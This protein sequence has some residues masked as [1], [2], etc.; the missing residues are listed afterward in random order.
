MI[1]KY[2]GYIKGDSTLSIQPWLHL[3]IGVKEGN[4]IY[5]SILVSKY[6]FIKSINKNKKK[7]IVKMFRIT[8]KLI[9]PDK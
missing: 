8:F 2:E 9:N 6:S 1:S 5:N 3:N 4:Q 7:R